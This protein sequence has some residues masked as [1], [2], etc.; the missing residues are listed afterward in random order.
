MAKKIEMNAPKVLYFALGMGL[1]SLISILFAP[2]SGDETRAY[3]S[4]KAR[5]ASDYASRKAQQ[6]QER[7]ETWAEQGKEAI[8]EKKQQ[9]TAAIDAG[10]QAYQRTAKGKAAGIN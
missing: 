4:Q 10:H 2:K 1:G 6:V 9:V 5:D 3:V 7:V 8:K